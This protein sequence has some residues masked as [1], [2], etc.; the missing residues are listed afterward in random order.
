[1]TESFLPECDNTFPTRSQ[2]ALTSSVIP[3]VHTQEII[4]LSWCFPGAELQ[5][6]EI[7]WTTVLLW[8]LP[9]VAQLVKNCLQWGRPGFDLSIG[10]ISW[11]K[12]RLPI[13]V[14]CPAEF[15]GLYSPGNRKQLDTTE[16]FHFHFPRLACLCT[17]TLCSVCNSPKLRLF[18]CRDVPDD[19][20]T[21]FEYTNC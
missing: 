19:F 1:M 7:L 2:G 10:K 21:D 8:G 18:T 20:L 17:D 3:G 13:L 11:R 12:E 16:W 4:A 9:F 14:F 6:A 15:H 5:A